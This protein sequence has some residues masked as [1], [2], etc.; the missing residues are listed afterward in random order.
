[1]QLNNA[2]GHRTWGSIL[3]RSN[4]SVAVPFLT[5]ERGSSFDFKQLLP[6]TSYQVQVAVSLSGLGQT[7]WS[8]PV[9]FHTQFTPD[10]Y[11]AVTPMWVTPAGGGSATSAG[12]AEFA[13]FRRVVPRPAAGSQMF[14]LLSAKPTPDRDMPHGRNTSHLLCAYKLWVNGVPL[15]TGPGRMVGGAIAVDTFNLTELLASV[16]GSSVIAIESYYQASLSPLTQGTLTQDPSRASNSVRLSPDSDDRGGVVALFHDANGATISAGPAGWE[17]FDAT[18]A[19]A[20][21]YGKNG[22]GAGTGSYVQP[23]ENIDARLYPTGWR[24]EATTSELLGGA[25]SPAVSR[26]VRPLIFHREIKPRILFFLFF[27][28]HARF[29]LLNRNGLQSLV[30]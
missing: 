5:W 24:T 3:V 30:L 13:L 26:F 29:C 12:P 10:E 19:F 2:S 17:A 1:M 8:D 7:P 27:T 20:P 15:G 14:L 18:A 9:D 21:D 23:H 11:S 28:Q 16:D 4:L 22:N 6:G 25:W